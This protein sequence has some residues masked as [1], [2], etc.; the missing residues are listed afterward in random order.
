[1][2]DDR[3]FSNR[4]ANGNANA[5]DTWYRETAPR[6]RAFSTF[7]LTN[8][9]LKTCCRRPSPKSGATRTGSTPNAVRLVRIYLALLDGRPQTGSANRK[10]PVNSDS[11]HRRPTTEKLVP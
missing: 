3:E 5:F 10:Y 8:K 9:R 4:I 11:I 7:S 1:L 2:F 6:L